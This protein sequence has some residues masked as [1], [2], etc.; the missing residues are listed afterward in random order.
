MSTVKNLAAG[1]D[2]TEFN[3][4]LTVTRNIVAVVTYQGHSIGLPPIAII[5]RF[6]SS[7]WGWKLITTLSYVSF[8]PLGICFFITNI[9]SFP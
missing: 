8:F 1:V 6:E 5:V 3:M 4:I 9:V 2:I 7:F